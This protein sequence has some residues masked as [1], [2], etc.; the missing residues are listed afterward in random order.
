MRAGGQAEAPT[1]PSGIVVIVMEP[2]GLDQDRAFLYLTRV[3]SGSETKRR[4]VAA[5]LVHHAAP[6][7]DPHSPASVINNLVPQDLEA[8]RRVLP[9]PRSH[10]APRAPSSWPRPARVTDHSSVVVRDVGY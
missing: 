7:S 8:V 2:A 5:H 3:S 4:K 1:S 9:G 6:L 10:P